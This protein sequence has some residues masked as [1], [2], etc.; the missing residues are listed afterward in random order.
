M[1]IDALCKISVVVP[2]YNGGEMIATCLRAINN[3]QGIDRATIEII[4]V[5]DASTDS[6]AKEAE[7]LCDQMIILKN[8]SGAAT[9]R[10]TGAGAASG[11]IIVFVD[12]DVILEPYLLSTFLTVFEKDDRV[13][14]AV[15]CYSEK[16]ADK[17]FLNIYH[18]TFTRYHHDQ[19][20][21]EIDWF[22]GGISAVR[23]EAFFQVGGFDERYQGASGEDLALGRILFDR[24]YK[25]VYVPEAQGAHAHQFTILNMLKN[26][27]LKAVT[28][29]KMMLS[30]IMPVKGPGFV[31]P[32]SIMTSFLLV[33]YPVLLLLHFALHI[34]HFIKI[35]ILIFSTLMIINR[36][37]YACVSKILDFKAS[38]LVPFIHWLQMYTIIAGA[39]M[40]VLGHLMGRTAFGRPKWI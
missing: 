39:A 17:K 35:S 9:A 8:N 10:N 34:P 7:T 24:G 30:N 37:Y 11:D 33:L 20:L 12:S 22:W 21:K 26:D 14:A 2:V 15:G 40:G 3:Q 13:V 32:G 1:R 19:S 25:T 5:D 16:P 29:M 18:N 6:G 4:V 28:G 27:Y 23:K 36:R 31:N 38:F